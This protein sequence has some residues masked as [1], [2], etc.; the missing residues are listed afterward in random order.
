MNRSKAGDPG[1]TE[2]PGDHILTD[3]RQIDAAV[4][5]LFAHARR[6]ILVR[7]VR[8]EPPYFRSAMMVTHFETLIAAGRHSRLQLLIEDAPHLFR[9]N[10]RL[11]ELCRR[12]SSY[13]EIRQLA[14]EYAADKELFV[15]SDTTAFVHQPRIDVPRAVTADDAPGT[16]QKLARRFDDIWQHVEPMSGVFTIGL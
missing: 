16:A 3:L 7:A 9:Y 4:Q 5:T 2:A 10:S 8:L 11:I 15:V 14:P 1:H 12:F 13:I 6:T